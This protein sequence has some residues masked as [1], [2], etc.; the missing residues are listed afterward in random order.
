[1]ND[2]IDESNNERSFHR[3]QN[4]DELFVTIAVV[5]SERM[6]EE[7]YF[8]A[9][10]QPQIIGAENAIDNA[11]WTPIDEATAENGML[12]R[13]YRVEGDAN[14]AD[15]QIDTFYMEQG[16]YLVVVEMY[17]ADAVAGDTETLANL[18]TILDSLRIKSNT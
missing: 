1:M 13:S 12:R 10:H 2:F 16:E 3:W 18:Q 9:Y 17:T 15:G 14:L 7:S 5:N 11:S 4:S 8:A 6:S